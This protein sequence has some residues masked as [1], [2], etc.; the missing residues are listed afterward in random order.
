MRV[1]E[2]LGSAQLE[3][4]RANAYGTSTEIEVG[5][6]S[7]A[8]DDAGV[9]RFM[10]AFLHVYDGACLET[11]G[12]AGAA[13]EGSLVVTSTAPI[14]G[15]FDVTFV[16]GSLRGTFAQSDCPSIVPHDGGGRGCL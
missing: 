3:C 16:G 9:P 10:F 7:V 5:T 11:A 8:P 2:G 4:C 1:R 12:A 15:T 6:Y 13:V 14:Q